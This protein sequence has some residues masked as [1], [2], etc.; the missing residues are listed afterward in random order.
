MMDYYRL[1]NDMS[2]PNRWFLGDISNVKDDWAFMAGK[3]VNEKKFNDLTVKIDKK[4]ASM[5]FTE[6]SAFIAPVVSEKFAACLADYKDEV[7]LIPVKVPGMKEQYFIMVIK[8]KIDCVDESRSIFSKFEKDDEVRPD[9]AGEYREIGILKINTTVVDKAIFRLDKFNV[10]IIINGDLK[11]K[12]EK[13]KLT[14]VKFS[15]VT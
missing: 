9:L 8:N 5:D 1:I 12:L 13:A 2:F 7:Q 3:P 6:T 10:Y 11:R 15:P 14:G 4:G